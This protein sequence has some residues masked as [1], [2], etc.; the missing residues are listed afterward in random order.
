MREIEP[1]TIRNEGELTESCTLIL[2]AL[3][4]AYLQNGQ[5][6]SSLLFR[7]ENHIKSSLYQTKN[8]MK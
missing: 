1:T 3:R 8:D 7:L 4:T 2:L 5:V 6:N